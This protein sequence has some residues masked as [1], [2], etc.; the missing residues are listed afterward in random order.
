MNSEELD[1]LHDEFKHGFVSAVDDG[2][3]DLSRGIENDVNRLAAEFLRLR[4]LG[5]RIIS[6]LA[7]GRKELMHEFDGK[8]A[9]VE[10]AFNNIEVVNDVEG[11]RGAVHVAAEQFSEAMNGLLE[12]K[13]EYQTA[14]KSHPL[15][16]QQVLNL[17]EGHCSYCD[18]KLGDDWHVDHVVPVS[19]GGP[20][21][22]ANYIPACPSCNVSKNGHHVLTFIKRQ[23]ERQGN[24]VSIGA[25]S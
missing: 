11:F 6:V 17:T 22:L 5:R 12:K 19:Q 25:A 14:N 20:D 7:D 3:L 9:A 1:F 8:L 23:R 16:R 24:V 21:S 4:L 10:Y 15:V 2:A 18:V 13:A